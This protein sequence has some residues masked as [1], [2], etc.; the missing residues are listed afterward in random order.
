MLDLCRF[1]LSLCVVQGHLLATG[2]PGLAWQA[3]FSFYVL[4]G[5]LMTLVLN[6][7]YGFGAVSFAR[8]LA[9]RVLRLYPAYYAILLVAILFIAWVSP[10]NQ[11]NGALGLPQTGSEWLANLSIVGL[12]GVDEGQVAV[13]RLVPTAWSLAIELF[14]YALLAAYFARSASR[15]LVLL[16]AGVAI[17]ATHYLHQVWTPAADYG[18]L[19]H[20]TVLQA[21]LIPFAVGGLAYFARLSRWFEPS[22]G[23][24][25]V[26]ALLLL[27]NGA[28]AAFSEFHRHVGGLYLVVVLNFG[29]IPM[30]FR[31][32]QAQGRRS[33]QAI[34]GGMAYPL[35]M[36]H[37][38]VG[39]VVLLAWNSLAPKGAVHF[40]LSL[41]ASLAVSLALYLGIDRNVEK[42]RLRLKRRPAPVVGAGWET[43]AA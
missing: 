38:F 3:V 33:W 1:L 12:V 25:A 35:F 20:Y 8:F 24:I 11:L 34:I 7:V 4:S 2:L 37:W 16:G 17:A 43:R 9:N 23:R 36:V 6:E 5:F 31:H 15:L 41:A 32:D 39:T 14:C 28:F 22:I 19:N 26:L 40:V 30:L 13:R 21:G 29:L 42:V 18:F 10:A 27:A